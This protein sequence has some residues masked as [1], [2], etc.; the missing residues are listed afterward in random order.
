MRKATIYLLLIMAI[1]AS[2]DK[3]ESD[4]VSDIIS[5]L[6][7]LS[8]SESKS[9]TFSTNRAWEASI[10]NNDSWFSVSPL[11]GSAGSANITV[12]VSENR[13]YDDRE[14]TLTI[15][16]GNT[17]KNVKIIQKQK[18]EIIISGNEFSFTHEGGTFEV[19]LSTNVEFNVSIPEDVD[20]LHYQSIVTRAL[21]D[22]VLT[23][24][25]DKNSSYMDRETFITISD[26]EGKFNKTIAVIQNES[27]F[28]DTRDGSIYTTVAIG[29]QVWMVENLAYLPTVSASSTGSNTDPHYYVLGYDGI[30]VKTAKAT[31]NYKTYG[32]LYNWTAAM[33]GASSNNSNRGV[34]GVCPDGW[35]L[36]SNAEWTQLVDYLGGENVAGG[37]L[38]KTDTSLWENPNNA[39]NE[40]GF[41]ALPGGYRYNYGTFHSIGKRGH[42]WSATEYSSTL[43][44]YQLIYHNKDD[45]DKNY[46]S[47]A[48]AFSVR[49][50][51]D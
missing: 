21:T 41:T 45:L 22:M 36:P 49:C 33:A 32:V 10:L 46:L 51:R 28:E 19:E 34:K 15:K 1:F 38:R 7:F 42:W 3:E 11:R 14:A 18:D 23:F 12:T 9:I 48:A 26:N 47:K 27:V 6:K 29:N 50:V 39:T 35:H 44:W 24:K 17:T 40:S 5:E 4:V 20:W 43:A 30:D 37:K 2:C 16:T 8:T 13:E 31:T 25:V